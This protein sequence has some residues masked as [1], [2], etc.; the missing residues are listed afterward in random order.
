MTAVKV[1]V[2]E[3]DAMIGLLLAEM[4]EEMGYDVRAVAATEEAAVAEAV[5]CEPGLVIADENLREGSGG[6]AV[7]RILLR[8]PVPCVF[9]GGAPSAL[10]WPDKG[11][12]RKPFLESDLVRA[13][14]CVLGGPGAAT[15]ASGRGRR[16]R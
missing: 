7:E 11:V 15:P 8:G 13:I 4:L 9:I 6:S 2:I 12:L 10:A 1:L 16:V 14:G 3:D 5:R